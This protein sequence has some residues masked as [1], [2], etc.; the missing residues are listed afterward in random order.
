MLKKTSLIILIVPFLISCSATKS[1]VSPQIDFNDVIT[2]QNLS[3]SEKIIELKI[4]LSRQEDKITN[5]E[6]NIRYFE[7]VFDSLEKKQINNINYLKTQIDSFKIEQSILIGPEFSNNITK[8]RN[9]VNIL[10]D[11]AFFMDSLYFSLV[12]DMVIIENQINSITNSLDEIDSSYDFVHDGDANNIDFN[13]EYKKA[14]EL[15]MSGEFNSS[16]ENFQN[17]I[18]IQISYD[19]ADNCQFWIGQIYFMKNNYKLA[20]DEFMKVL[21][22][23]NSNK[24]EDSMYKMGL[25]YMKTNQSEK[26]IEI[27]NELIIN[28]PKSKYF[29]KSN[30]FLLNLK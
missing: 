3:D 11:R 13:Y 15:Y 12:T 23:D 8:L 25:C 17:L 5:L 24:I 27:F 22:Y 10:E 14:L 19:L 1:D 20:I 28:Y 21:K 7:N 29:N 16:L 9:K 18:N 6:N 2:D 4:G 30:E 26:A